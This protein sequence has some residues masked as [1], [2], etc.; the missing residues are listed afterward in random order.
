LCWKALRATMRRTIAVRVP[1][2]L[3][4]ELDQA[5]RAEGVSRSDIVR[6]SVRE[7][8]FRRH[9]RTLRRS[10]TAKAAAHGVLTDEDVF[11][12]IS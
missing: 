1:D 10:M 2:P 11:E 3:R 9:F 6:R 8:L 7:Y 4:V 12:R 5:A